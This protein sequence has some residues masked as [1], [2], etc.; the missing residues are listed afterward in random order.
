MSYRASRPEDN[1]T[2]LPES[3]VGLPEDMKRWLMEVWV[4][5]NDNDRIVG[6]A[7]WTRMDMSA[8]SMML[9]ARLLK[10]MEK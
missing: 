2:K 10:T 9:L 7:R 4:N 5:P 8:I 1:A 6:D 3:M